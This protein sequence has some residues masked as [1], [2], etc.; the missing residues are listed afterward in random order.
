MAEVLKLPQ[1]AQDHRVP[2]VQERAGRIDPQLYPKRPT[3]NQPPLELAG[4]EDLDAPA[5]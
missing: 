2:E 1:L 3:L 4:S 5:A